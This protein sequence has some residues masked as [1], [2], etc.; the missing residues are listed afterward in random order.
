MGTTPPLLFAA[1]GQ[2]DPEHAGRGMAAVVSL[3]YV[4][5]IAGPAFVGFVAQ[6]TTLAIGLAAVAG[7]SLVI[8]LFGGVARIADTRP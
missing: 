5:L 4:G 6:A 3:G 7:L 2:A 8:W 1:G